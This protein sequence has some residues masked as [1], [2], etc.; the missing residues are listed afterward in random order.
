VSALLLLTLAG[1]FVT[2]TAFARF[3]QADADLGLARTAR[4]TGNYEWSLSPASKPPTKQSKRY[5]SICTRE[6]WGHVLLALMDALPPQSKPDAELMD[7]AR[8]LDRHYIPTR[9][10]NGFERGAPVDFY[11]QKD[12]DEA[13][14]HAEAILGFCRNQIG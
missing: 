10:L 1:V 6:A 12:A 7:R 3:R 9:Y 4:D 8:V 2:R 14:A 5:F 13:I 11:S